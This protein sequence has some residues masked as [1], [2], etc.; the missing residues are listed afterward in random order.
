MSVDLCRESSQK[1]HHVGLQNSWLLK[2]CSNAAVM[3]FSNSSYDFSQI[4]FTVYPKLWVRHSQSV[5]SFLWGF[6]PAYRDGSH[7]HGDDVKGPQGTLKWDGFLL[8]NVP[9]ILFFPVPVQ[10]PPL[11]NV[12]LDLNEDRVFNNCSWWRVIV[13]DKCIKNSFF[14]FPHGLYTLQNALRFHWLA[15]LRPV[16]GTS[17]MWSW[18]WLIRCFFLKSW[19][20]RHNFEKYLY[21]TT[22]FIRAPHR[23]VWPLWELYVMRDP[24][25]CQPVSPLQAMGM[26]PSSNGKM[27]EAMVASI[28]FCKFSA[29]HSSAIFCCDSPI[30]SCIFSTP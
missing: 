7:T 2:W 6:F 24:P 3:A 29:Q 27:P 21:A 30:L 22:F 10:Q 12:F 25:P 14:G 23:V 1:W 15:G 9:C 18:F 8:A 20:V 26:Q 28:S 13:T 19:H 5:F 16:F 11:N 4:S 17:M